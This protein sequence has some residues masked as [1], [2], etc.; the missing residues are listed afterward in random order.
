MRLVHLWAF[1]PHGAFVC[2]VSPPR[3]SHECRR[4]VL[5]NDKALFGLE[6]TAQ[7]FSPLFLRE[8]SSIIDFKK[9]YRDWFFDYRQHRSS[10]W[11]FIDLR[12]RKAIKQCIKAHRYINTLQ[13]YNVNGDYRIRIQQFF[14]TCIRQASNIDSYWLR[15]LFSNNQ[16][17][18]CLC[19]R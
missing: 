10:L 11:T 7:R 12:Q 16:V 5:P 4:L 17:A 2:L 13:W 15:G 1:Y 6:W 3:L 8:S 19:C 18:N 9:H 14:N